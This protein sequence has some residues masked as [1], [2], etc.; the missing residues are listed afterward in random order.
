MIRRWPQGKRS[1][2]KVEQQIGDSDAWQEVRPDAVQWNPPAQAVW[3]PATE[4]LQPT[5]TLLPDLKGE[6]KLD[7]KVGDNTASIVFTLKDAGPDAKD[8]AARLLLVREPKG[9]FLPVG[10]SQRYAILVDKDG[11]QEPAADVQWPENFENEYVKWDAPVLTAK[12]EGYTQFMRAEVARRSVLWHTTTYRPGEFATE[13]PIKDDHVPPDWVKIFS[14]QGLQKVQQVRFAVGA[15]FTDFKVE[16]HYREGYTRFVTKKCILRTPEP[17]SSAILSRRTWQVC[18]SASRLDAGQRRVPGLGLQVPLDVVV[19]PDVEIDKIAV[20]PG[21]FTLKPGETY[22]LKVMGYKDGRSVGYITD[23]GNLTWKSSKPDVARLAGSSVIASSLGMSEITVERKGLDGKV[24]TSLPAQ[25][26]VSNTIEGDLRVEPKTITMVLGEVQQL[27]DQIRVLRNGL[28]V[29]QQAMAVPESPGVV[30]FDAATRTLHAENVGEV[31]LGI[32]MGDKMTRVRVVVTPGA[33]TGTVVVEP[34][35]VLLA[36]GQA[37]RVSVFIETPDGQKIDRTGTAVFKVA[38]PTVAGVDEAIGRVR[39][40]QSGKTEI[41]VFILGLQPAIV[42]VEVTKEEITELRAEP[43]ALEMAAGEHAHLQV[44]GRAATS[45]SK[46]MFPQP[47]LKVV[48]RKGIVVD[49]S[50]GEDVQ[51]KAVGEDQ[52]DITWHDKLKIAVPVKVAANVISGLQIDPGEKTVN[53]T[54]AVIYQVSGMRGGN[55]VILTPDDGVRLNVTDPTIAAVANGTTVQTTGLGQTKVVA[56]YGGQ[57]A[58]AV[59]NV[60]QG[61]VDL[62]D[63]RGI[64]VDV[65]HDHVYDD[66]GKVV[67]IGQ[68]SDTIHGKVVAPSLRAAIL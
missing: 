27:G 13:P 35:S 47:D 46:E 64:G 15:T 60:T 63:T 3:T 20:E 30:R 21:S 59:L 25:L 40:L 37:Q 38:D 8:P 24:F 34:G 58:E 66:H 49:V 11:H 55:R 2:L 56:D 45:G 65:G 19:T 32:T 22:P 43:P 10:Q 9:K 28:D 23:L 29:S 31:P 62:V 61:P 6:V 17:P 5:L 16:V 57:K 52:I 41:K 7:A 68:T 18:R 36:P 48:P 33:V 1:A 39:A 26:L 14:L 4:N 67:V 42:P 51:A 53:V 50:G 54:Q 44:F 12:Q